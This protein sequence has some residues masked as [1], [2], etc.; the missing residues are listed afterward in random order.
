MGFHNFLLA[1]LGLGESRRARHTH[2]QAWLGQ[3]RWRSLLAQLGLRCLS[4]SW[5]RVSGQNQHRKLHPASTNHQRD[6]T[7]N[8]RN[9]DACINALVFRYKAKL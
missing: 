7:E 2:S 3:V 9:A 5:C 1:K 6:I 8:K 4:N